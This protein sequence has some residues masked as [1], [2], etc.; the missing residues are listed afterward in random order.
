[1]T[2]GVFAFIL[3]LSHPF[4]FICPLLFLCLLSFYALRL[5]SVALSLLSSACPLALSLWVFGCAV[6]S[7][8]LSVYTQK[9]RA[10]RFVPCVLS[11]PVV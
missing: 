11:C 3:S 6:V 4:F 1:M 7:F 8:S 2:C 5:S 9:E 10:Q